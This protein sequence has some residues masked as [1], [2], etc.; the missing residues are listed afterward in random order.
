MKCLKRKYALFVTSYFKMLMFACMIF[1][2]FFMQQTFAAQQTVTYTADNLTFTAT[3]DDSACQ[4]STVTVIFN[5]KSTGAQTSTDYS[6]EGFVPITTGFACQSVIPPL[7]ESYTSFDASA[8][9]QS[10]D[11]NSCSSC[12]DNR[13][14]WELSSPFPTLVDGFEMRVSFTLTECGLVSYQP[15]IR[16][17]DHDNSLRECLG[18]VPIT[19]YIAPY[20]QLTDVVT[21]PICQGIASLTG[22]LPG[23]ICT[24][25]PG[26]DCP[27]CVPCTACSG[28]S[29]TACT[30]CS[31]ISGCICP[32]T[33]CDGYTGCPACTSC[34]PCPGCVACASFTGPCGPQPYFYTV[35]DPTGGSVA[36]LDQTGG[37]Y[38]FTFDPT[39]FGT[40]SFNYNI[41]S[42]FQP[43]IFC[44]ATAPGT[45]SIGIKQPPSTTDSDFVVCAGQNITGDLGNFVT[46]PSGAIFSFTLDSTTCTGFSL[47]PSGIFSFTAPTGPGLCTFDYT[48]TDLTPP[49]CSDTGFGTVTI[50]E[51]PVAV[52]QTIVTCIDTPVDGTLT[53]VGGIIPYTFAV[54]SDTNGTAVINDP[55]AGTFTFTPDPGFSG[56]ANFTFSVTDFNGCPSL[57][58]GT[59]TINVNTPVIPG[60]GAF[61]G[62]QGTN[63]V[64]T[65][66]GLITGGTGPFI[67]GAVPPTVGG[68]VVVNS[69]GTFTFFPNF[70]FTGPASFNFAVTGDSC[71]P[72]GVGNVTIN[73]SPAPQV[74]GST[75]DTCPGV[76]VTGDLINNLLSP[77]GANIS[78]T[79]VGAPSNG[80]LTLDPSGPY[81]FTPTPPTFNGLAGFN[82][83]AID[84]NLIC[85][86]NVAR[87]NVIVHPNP[88]VTTGVFSVCDNSVLNGNLN[89]L[90]Q[91]EA[92]FTY[93]Q[94][95]APV[96]G[97]LVLN[98]GGAFTFTPTVFGPA[99]GGFNYIVSSLFGCT[100]PGA[101]NITINPSP[102]ATTGANIACGG[103]PVTGTLVPLV[104]GGT[105]PYFFS[106]VSQTNG[107]ASVGGLNGIYTFTPN[108]GVT[109]GSFVFRATDQNTCSATSSID[110]S[111]NPGPEAS[112]GAFTAC[113]GVT[114]FDGS[115]TG[116]VTG[117]SGTLTYTQT[118][119]LPTCGNVTV[120]PDGTFTFEPNPGF[121]GS[122]VF[123]F[124]VTDSGTPSCF[125]VGT[126]TFTVD[127]SPFASGANFDA[128]Q[129]TLF[130][131]NL[132]G[133]VSGG[134][135][136]FN[137]FQ[138]GAAPVCGTV[139]VATGGTFT[140]QPAPAFVG[141]CSFNWFVED[142][143]PCP[144]NIATATINVHPTP[145]AADTG[146]VGITGPNNICENTKATGNLNDLMSVGTPPYFFNAFNS[147]NGSVTLNPSGP[148]T[149]NPTS[150]FTGAASF[151]FRG[152]DSF[153]C[154]SNTGTV[155]INVN[156]SPTLTA[157]DPVFT[158]QNTPVTNQVFASGGTPPYEF[159]VVSVTHGSCIIDP[160]T[161]IYTFIPDFNF[162]GNAEIVF[163]VDDSLG[164]S[165]QIEVTVI[166]TP[167]PVVSSTSVQS[168]QPVVFGSLTGLVSGGTPPFTFSPTGTPTCGEVTINSDGTFVYTGPIGPCTFDFVV[169]DNTPSMCFGTG[170]VTISQTATGAPI[171]GDGFFCACFN[172]PVSGNLSNFVSGGIPPYVYMIVGT[173]VG[174][175]VIINPL[176]G[177]FIFKP[178][179]GFT[180]FASF[181]YIAKDSSNIFC[182]S[183]IGTVTIQVP[184]CPSTGLTAPTGIVPG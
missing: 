149:F 55:V 9:P 59:V 88:I 10:A 14:K 92:P 176:T 148:Y 21:G 145:V 97:N 157:E 167:N 140:F 178:A 45:V 122:C 38:E 15:C 166:V 66:T 103:V 50:L 111:V 60:T 83:Q 172:T 130:T 33:A 164:C 87:I 23:P 180:G 108:N 61:S 109:T 100:S 48:V 147:I 32:C 168:C 40:A 69:N 161:G 162:F 47:N 174:G 106:I 80:T 57:A 144:S 114:S 35:S 28:F 159:S 138:T 90:V 124:Q 39:F 126:V 112:N 102:T 2:L 64:G 136:P 175:T 105:P 117:G 121:V 141:P 73:F 94:D 65:L 89:T 137:F 70:N 151:Q 81:S 113:L 75:F 104:N 118:G 158:C 1:H 56:Q 12:S 143:T 51:A 95:G 169:T 119:P 58:D 36:L 72:S 156:D 133:F 54:T 24:A 182:Q 163:Q 19:F 181:Q 41:V 142:S 98:G 22:L 34:L 5:I 27:S 170:S 110:I 46:G 85:P 107:I 74:T 127:E 31:G 18:D 11:I 99:A 91:G 101:V 129:D 6:L 132:N 125:D 71:P 76:T 150:N 177:F 135:P 49:P 173:P 16:F 43:I 7:P 53:A 165:A 68:V 62:C 179:P 128:C 120:N 93:V 183:N 154:L 131:G 153:G 20:V 160:V 26:F 86:S 77:S 44:S 82:F 63:F 123:Q 115:L 139:N 17:K 84:A 78:F 30:A 13:G 152:R 67:F 52:D 8:E 96:N 134:F 42:D 79:S 116:L 155:N 146:P 171:A 4:G 37:L 184:C 29:G 25:Q 3:W